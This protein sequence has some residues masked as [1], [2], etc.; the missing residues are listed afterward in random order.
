MVLC[1]SSNTVI[2]FENSLSR[3]STQVVSLD[4]QSVGVCVKVN[5]RLL[6]MKMSFPAELGF[7]T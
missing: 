4:C 2:G 5:G 7:L 3:V 6:Q 1:S